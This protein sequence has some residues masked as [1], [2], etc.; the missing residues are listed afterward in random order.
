M[1]ILLI[2][3][4]SLVVM[5]PEMSGARIRAAVYLK[6]SAQVSGASIYLGQIANIEGDEAL[7]KKME[8]IKVASS[9]LPGRSRNL[10]LDYI[11][12]R[13]YQ[14]RIDQGE[15]LFKGAKEVKVTHSF[16]LMEK[17]ELLEKVRKLVF[18]LVEGK[19]VAVD[20]DSSRISFPLVIP[21]GKV[22]LEGKIFSPV[23]LYGSSTALI[24]I[25][26]DDKLL[27]TLSFP[28]KFKEFQEVLV[29]RRSLARGHILSSLD[30]AMEKREISGGSSDL[31]TDISDALGSQL[32]RDL[33]AG[34]V[35]EKK[36]LKPPLLVNQGDWV[37]LIAE[38][39]G[40]RVLAKGRALEKGG[41]GEIIR[42][43]NIDSHKSLEGRVVD[44]NTVRVELR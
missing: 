9:P 30:L 5:V 28:L 16:N 13:L 19:N 42:V 4:L 1:R 14:H 10:S 27:R 41:K 6:D 12:V 36:I 23:N 44:I 11:W 18:P 3:G 17:E 29:V 38:T 24:D 8:K 25:C 20:I 15:V 21:S 22:R 34:S 40:V 43:L 7:V 32:A 35:L 33:P 2:L 39:P 31:V 37:T 26:I